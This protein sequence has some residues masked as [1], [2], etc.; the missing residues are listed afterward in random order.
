MLATSWLRN[1]QHRP[2]KESLQNLDATLSLRNQDNVARRVKILQPDST[3]FKVAP[4]MEVTYTAAG[5]RYGEPG[6]ERFL[7]P[8]RAMGGG[9]LLDMPDELDFGLS[10][11]KYEA[12]KTIMAP[13]AE[14]RGRE[15]LVI[16]GDGVETYVMLRGRA[17]TLDSVEPLGWSEMEGNVNEL[18][19]IPI[20]A[21]CAV[22]QVALEPAEHVDYGA[23]ALRG[24][25]S[26]G[27]RASEPDRIPPLVVDDHFVIKWI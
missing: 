5:Q 21:R 12:P 6:R 16:Y 18:A 17:E 20:Q 4:G 19:S 7:V 9:A 24:A 14:G 3:F 8:I 1:L 15:L 27:S 10:P 26:A 13:R 11:V 2:A 23:L 22:P 25:A